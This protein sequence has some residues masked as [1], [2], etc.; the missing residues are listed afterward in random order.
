MSWTPSSSSLFTQ[1]WSSLPSEGPES[2]AY[3]HQFFC[4]GAVQ[5]I[6]DVYLAKYPTKVVGDIWT[7]ARKHTYV[8]FRSITIQDLHTFFPATR[9]G[10]C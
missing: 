5:F 2:S 8:P 3:V 9:I 1:W 4:F 7:T 6:S 10:L